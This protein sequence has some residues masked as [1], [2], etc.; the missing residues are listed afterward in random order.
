MVQSELAELIGHVNTDTLTAQQTADLWDATKSWIVVGLLK[1][2]RN[3]KLSKRNTYP[4]KIKRIYKGLDQSMEKARQETAL[5]RTHPHQYQSAK[6]G[7][8]QLTQR[9]AET[10]REWVRFKSRRLFQSHTWRDGKTTKQSFKRISNKF[11]DNIIRTLRQDWGAPAT[12]PQAKADTMASA[13]RS[14]MQGA[15]ASDS[16]VSKI[17]QWMEQGRHEDTGMF[18]TADLTTEATVVAAR[19]ASRTK[20]AVQIA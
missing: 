16:T 11:G 8:I 13:W 5:G 2:K 17:T 9:I 10:K 7:V 6:D 14:I 18:A 15:A 19:P 12:T 4:K 3:P 20:L 1:A